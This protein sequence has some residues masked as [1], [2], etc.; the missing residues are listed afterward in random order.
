M[1]D[2]IQEYK[3]EPD[4]NIDFSKKNA[5]D[6]I[7]IEKPVIQ[8]QKSLLAIHQKRYERMLVQKSLKS[9]SKQTKLKSP[10]LKAQNT[11][12]QQRMNT[13]NLDTDA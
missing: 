13:I 11:Y 1:M 8:Q 6:Q 12:R 9:D 4:L 2:K 7:Q 5:V 3:K 10:T